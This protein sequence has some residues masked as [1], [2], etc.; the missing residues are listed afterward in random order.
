MG[1]EDNDAE[2][3]S[4]FDPSSEYTIT[5]FQQHTPTEATLLKQE[6]TENDSKGLIPHRRTSKDRHTK[7]EGRGRRI[8]MPALCAARVFQLT[9]ELGHKSD[10]ETIQWLLNHAE[11]AIV[12]ATGTGTVPAI[13]VSVNGTL[14]VPTTSS[15]V[16]GKRLNE[17][18]TS[19]FAPVAPVAS[20][21]IVPVW[22]M[23]AHGDSGGALFMIPT[24]V[25]GDGSSSGHHFSQIWGVRGGESSSS[26]SSICG[27]SEIYEKKELQF[28][29][30][31]SKE[32]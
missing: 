12:K 26:S 9:R 8:R 28:M 5:P 18:L 20:Q 10:G 24:T 14:K 4:R 30:G 19:S 32:S 23:G 7:V 16:D 22:T 25:S 1:S 6:P 29:F 27:T 15:N 11:D 2:I 21:S 17:T 31:S 3:L 13:A